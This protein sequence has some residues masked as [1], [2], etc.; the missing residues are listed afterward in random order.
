MMLLLDIGSTLASGLSKSPVSYLI[1]AFNLPEQEKPKMEAALFCTNSSTY[2]E[3]ASFLSEHFSR[4]YTTVADKVK[5]IWDEQINSTA[6]WPGALE[7]LQQLQSSGIKIAY[8]SNTWHPFYI[9]FQ[10]IIFDQ[11]DECPA[12]LSFRLGLMKPDKAIYF[13][14]LNQLEI[15]PEDCIMVGDT[16]THDVLPAMEI[17]MKT[18]WV[19]HRPEKE[20]RS[21]V[22]VL[23][24]DSPAPTLTIPQI[25]EL[26]P[27]KIFS[28]ITRL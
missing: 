28:L 4:S 12:F 27:N 9:S 19:L 14:A 1:Q 7:T 22:K 26:T 20:K 11:I 15:Q 18:V 16:Y 13:S 10:Q 2:Q 8:I 21:I 5:Q 17:G 23:N 24:G 3:L 6:I 25:S